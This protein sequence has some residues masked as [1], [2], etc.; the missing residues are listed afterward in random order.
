[1]SFRI[2]ISVLNYRSKLIPD[3]NFGKVPERTAPCAANGR[4]PPGEHLHSHPGLAQ[5]YRP[6]RRWRRFYRIRLRSTSAEQARNPECGS[7]RAVGEG[8]F[9]IVLSLLIAFF[10]YRD[11]E[12]AAM[13]L[14]ATVDRISGGNGKRLLE[15]AGATV[16]SVLYGVLGTALLQGV[17]A[18]VGF[19]VAG[20]P[21]ASFLEFVT[22]LVSAIPAAPHWSPHRLPS[23]CTG[24]VR[25]D[26]P[27]S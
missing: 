3:L 24:R 14:R 4:G 6:T 16:R 20:V 12:A 22:L 11:G 27:P 18:A 15:L 26:G 25:R 2:V 1:L 21:G 13:R 23:G 10:L 8:I 5:G 9:Q 19:A 17:M 7:G